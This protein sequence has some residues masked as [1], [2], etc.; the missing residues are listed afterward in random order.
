MISVADDVKQ[1]NS[2]EG[3]YLVADF[4]D[5]SSS[6]LVEYRMSSV[7]LEETTNTIVEVP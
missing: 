6:F 5:D 4:I 3:I 2:T 1:Y 7:L